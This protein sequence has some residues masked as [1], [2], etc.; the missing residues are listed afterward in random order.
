MIFGWIEGVKK[1][2][3]MQKKRVVK[4]IFQPERNEQQKHSR[5]AETE[6]QPRAA[7]LALAE[8]AVDRIGPA[9]VFREPGKSFLNGGQRNEKRN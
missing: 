9:L 6:N 2:K 1:H 8:F 7:R 3:L 4:R 5:R